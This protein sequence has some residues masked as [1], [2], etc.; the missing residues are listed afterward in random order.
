MFAFSLT[1][2]VG[3][4]PVMRNYERLTDVLDDTIDAR[5][6]LGI[7][8][9]AADVQRV[10]IGKDVAHVVDKNFFQ[11]VKAS[12]SEAKRSKSG[13]GPRKRGSAAGP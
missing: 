1:A 3:G 2:T 9:R 4:V 12:N 5:V 10:G 6:F 8:F 7:H 11:P 13:A